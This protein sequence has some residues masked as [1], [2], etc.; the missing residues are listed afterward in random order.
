MSIAV[1]PPKA[2]APLVVDPDAVLTG[3]TASQPF[4][5]IARGHVHILERD[6]SVELSQLPQRHSLKVGA[7]LP[8]RLTL[9]QTGGVPVPKA[10]N[11]GT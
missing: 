4:E 7:Q 1:D 11:H 6:G 10:P 8:N 3:A 2:D 9:E 5:S